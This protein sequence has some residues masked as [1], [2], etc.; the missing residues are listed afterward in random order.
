[1]PQSMWSSITLAKGFKSKLTPCGTPK[2]KKLL[3][4]AKTN[5]IAFDVN[6]LSV[7]RSIAKSVAVEMP[8]IHEG[9]ALEATALLLLL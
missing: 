8:T 3:L 2:P 6:E 1:M 4:G 5:G 9:K 7:A